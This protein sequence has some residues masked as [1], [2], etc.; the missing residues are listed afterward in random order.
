M[1]VS[2]RTGTTS[3]TTRSTTSRESARHGVDL[4]R[5]EAELLELGRHLPVDLRGGGARGRRRLLRRLEVRG[6]LLLEREARHRRRA[7]G[8][9]PL[10]LHRRARRRLGRGARG[11]RVCRSASWRAARGRSRRPAPRA[12]A[13]GGRGGPGAAPARGARRVR[14]AWPPAWNRSACEVAGH[15]P[16]RLRRAS[17]AGCALSS[18][19]T[20]SIICCVSKGLSMWSSACAAEPLAASNA[21]FFDDRIR[22]GVPGEAFLMAL[23]RS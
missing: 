19:L 21:F 1:I 12:E 11:G 9:A 16:R 3:H 6:A 15:R 8:D 22:T 2:A 10:P 18:F 7:G 5:R 23:H 14:R 4:G 20:L 13:C 17:G